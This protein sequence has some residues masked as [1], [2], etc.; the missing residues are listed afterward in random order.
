MNFLA[1]LQTLATT[2]DSGA[3]GAVLEFFADC[4]EWFFQLT[5]SIGIPSYILAIFFFTLIIKILTQ[6]FQNKQMRSSRR[7]QMLAPEVE[8]IRKQYAND[9]RKQQ[10]KIMN[11]YKEHK[12]SP[13]A[14]CLPLM[15]QLPILFA[16]FSSIS[17]FATGTSGH[18][19]YP[20]Y[21]SFWVWEDLS[22]PVS[23]AALP[24]LLPLLAAGSTLLQQFVTTPNRKDRTTKIM[25]IAMPLVFFFVVR[26]FPVLMAFY[27]IF[28]GLIGAAISYPLLRRWNRIDQEEI[29]RKR[30][31]KAAA[32]EARKA[33]KAAAK[34]AAKDKHKAKNPGKELTD[35]ELEYMY[36]EDDDFS[37][38][39]TDPERKF[40]KWLRDQGY[41][42]RREKR[43]EHPYSNKLK[44]MEVIYD[45]TGCEHEM[46]SLRAY[47]E[48]LQ[49]KNNSPEIFGISKPTWKKKKA[50]EE[51]NKKD[52]Q[53]IVATKAKPVAEHRPPSVAA[54]AGEQPQHDAPAEDKDKQD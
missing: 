22:V 33:R 4:I 5:K 43:K 26:S 8:E 50:A 18:P 17:T 48:K 14:G 45:A 25:M 52:D 51:E 16:L 42:I 19:L 37:D 7:M 23:Q 41:S 36:Y 32:E 24:F 39:E 9:P 27:W 12:A 28:Y 38:D 20:E 29:E 47:Y 1:S 11:L 10:E 2:N 13:T 40:R 44:T 15:V 31:Q 49:E 6:P 34:A 46:K 53:T 3:W 21:F 35:E 30:A 54:A